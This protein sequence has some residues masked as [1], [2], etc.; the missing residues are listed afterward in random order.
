MVSPSL[1]IRHQTNIPVPG[2]PIAGNRTM[3]DQVFKDLEESIT[4]SFIEHD[5][6]LSEYMSDRLS[7]RST[8]AAIEFMTRVGCPGRSR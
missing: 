8:A 4:Y 3:L 5:T 2:Y 1:G 6:G 7:R